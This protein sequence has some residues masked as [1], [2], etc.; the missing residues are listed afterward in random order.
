M[1][2]TL[3]NSSSLESA[4]RFQRNLASMI[5]VLQCVFTGRIFITLILC[6]DYFALLKYGLIRVRT[7]SNIA[8]SYCRLYCS[9]FSNKFSFTEVV[10]FNVI[11]KKGNAEMR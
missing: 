2:K 8:L 7:F 5:K 10:Q 1:V 3:Q 6:K 9:C 11:I 4:D